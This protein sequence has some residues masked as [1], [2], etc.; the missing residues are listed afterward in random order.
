MPSPLQIAIIGGGAS[1][2][3]LGA[4]LL[5]RAAGPLRVLLFE[6]MSG[7]GGGVA[8]GTSFAGHL[9]NVPAGRMSGFPDQPAHF[10]EW[11][12]ARAGAARFPASVATGDFLPR[13]L[14]GRYLAEVLA[15]AQHAA[16][17]GVELLHVKGEVVDIE[18]ETGERRLRTGDGSSFA[19]DEV[20]LA[21]GNLPGEYPIR[22][23][24]PIYHS[25]RYVH[26][27][28]RPGTL[29]GIPADADVLMVGAGLTSIDLILELAAAGHRGTI[30]ALSRRGLLPQAHRAAVPYHDFLGGTELPRTVRAL[31]RCL[32]DEVSRA[33]EAGIDW[34]PVLDAIRPHSPALWRGFSWEERARFMRHVRPFWEVHRHRLAPPVAEKIEELRAAGRVKFYAG[35]LEKLLEQPNGAVAVFRERGTKKV[36][37][38]EVAKVINC[39]GPR[40]DYSKYQHPLL[41]NLL[42][43]G[44]ID[45]DP[46]AL[47]LRATPDG[48]V[49]RHRG[50]AVGWLHTLGAPLKGELWECTAIPEIRAQAER[51]A[52]RLVERMPAVPLG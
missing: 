2:T 8:Y 13:Q 23:S 42:A 50:G 9:L 33:A 21:L 51:L 12:A 17:A 49:L 39:T 26:V 5:R 47:G 29:A 32:R 38:L 34:R 30:H 28:W 1:G 4:Q 24:L 16:P 43:R 48:E 22:R 45:H 52:R 27:P 10:L 19:A 35:R 18:D 11:A 36:R 40:T 44:W 3:L 6:R 37:T 20:V 41:V 31:M 15:D 25:Q 46:L 14:F 7:T